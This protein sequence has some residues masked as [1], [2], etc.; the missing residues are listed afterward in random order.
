MKLLGLAIFF[1]LACA[2]QTLP[3][4]AYLATE[5]KP[6]DAF[7]FT[8]AFL[9][10]LSYAKTAFRPSTIS[11]DAGPLLQLSDL[12]FRVK[13]AGLDYECAAELLRGYRRSKDTSIALTA[14]TTVLTYQSVSD[15][16][17]ES[18]VLLKSLASEGSEKIGSADLA[19]KMADL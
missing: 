3:S 14:M 15:M 8:V 16:E 19:E 4:C 11:A 7:Q 18:V 2:E 9:E 17:K 5:V 6:D 13:A 12:I 1:G 10:S